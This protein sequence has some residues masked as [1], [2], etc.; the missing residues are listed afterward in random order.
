[1]VERRRA[2]PSRSFRPRSATEPDRGRRH[3]QAEHEADT[4][5]GHDEWTPEAPTAWVGSDAAADAYF[6]HPAEVYPV[7][8]VLV[9]HAAKP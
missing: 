2:G 5:R 9:V 7:E 1:M 3:E 8:S 6:T 4:R